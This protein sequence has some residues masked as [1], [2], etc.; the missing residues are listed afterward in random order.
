[1]SVYQQSSIYVDHFNFNPKHTKCHIHSLLTLTL[2]SKEK[3]GLGFEIVP[4]Y[5]K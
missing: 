1:M 5:E 2:Q 3:R 4:M